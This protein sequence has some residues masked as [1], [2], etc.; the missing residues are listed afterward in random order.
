MSGS[1]F[2]KG[3]AVGACIAEMIVEGGARTAP[4]HAFRLSRFR[5]GDP[6]V[7]QSYDIEPESAA[8]LG[9]ENMVH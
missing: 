6:I 4:V 2:K 1:G 3:P 7:S 8:L 5:E 9:P